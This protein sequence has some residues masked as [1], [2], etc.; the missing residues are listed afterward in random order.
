MGASICGR[1]RTIAVACTFAVALLYA[2]GSAA[3]QTTDTTVAP[4]GAATGLSTFFVISADRGSLVADGD[5]AFTLTLRDTDPDAIVFTDR[6]ERFAGAAPV[7]EIVRRWKTAG[8][9][10][11]P[12]NA[13]V[14][15]LDG[16]GRGAGAAFELT[17][18]K[19][20]RRSVTFTAQPLKGFDAGTAV[21]RPLSEGLA[22]SAGKVPERF[23]SAA[24]FI[25]PTGPALLQG[26]Y[27]VIVNQTG[28]RVIGTGTV[29]QY[30]VDVATTPLDNGGTTSAG[31]AGVEYCSV[32]YNWTAGDGTMYSFKIG[33]KSGQK[34]TMSSSSN[35]SATNNTSP[36]NPNWMVTFTLRPK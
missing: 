23:G 3:G 12:P 32:Q 11:D 6:P 30:G 26:C 24:L 8:L 14:S 17:H 21:A 5:G 33:N 28:Q 13:V 20:G 27:A 34:N 29:V 22:A 35:V 19:A 25:D 16:K 2:G 18:P 10:D 7:P 15:V 36:S 4:A 9:A 1:R 31:G